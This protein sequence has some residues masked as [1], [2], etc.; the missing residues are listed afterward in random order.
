MHNCSNRRRREQGA[1]EIFEV[2]MTGNFRKLMTN[3]KPQIQEAQTKPNR[4]YAKK[5]TQR[6]YHIQTPGNQI[7]KYL[8]KAS[9]KNSLP[10]EEQG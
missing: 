9:G 4:I 1:E 2:I 3:T 6:Y 5:S 7:K 10:T 8:S